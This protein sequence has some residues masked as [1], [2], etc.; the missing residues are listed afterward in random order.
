MGI[1]VLQAKERR[2]VRPLYMDSYSAEILENGG[3]ELRTVVV[4]NS[5]RCC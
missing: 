2:V 4:A 3:D 1:L 5:E